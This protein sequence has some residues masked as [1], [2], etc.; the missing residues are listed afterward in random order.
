MLRSDDTQE[1]A[2]HVARPEPRAPIAGFTE[3]PRELPLSDRVAE[4]MREAIVDGTFKPG[5]L[6]P[7]ERELGDD[8]GVSRT[9]VREAIRSLAAKGMLATR[10]G[11]G[12]RVA[13][14]DSQ[15]VADSLH[16][17]LQGIGG[18]DYSSVHEVRTVLERRMAHLAAE[19]AT[20]LQVDELRQVLEHMR[21]ATDAE[22][23]SIEDVNFHRKIAEMTENPLFPVLMDSIR[24]V[25]LEIRRATLSVPGRSAT[26]VGYH[27]R[28]LD[29]I[30][31]HDPDGA[32]REMR[33]HL[34]ESYRIWEA[35]GLAHPKRAGT[36]SRGR[37]H[38][39]DAPVVG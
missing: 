13:A 5:D 39:V 24:G 26:A 3:M 34:Q 27:E 10:S 14:V 23:A 36:R 37:P 1:A 7:S 22:A 20:D 29:R 6:L 18:V 15:V 17:Y 9:V 28:I 25:L 2:N 4:R 35:A 38:P 32:E 21:A 31:Q 30:E 19:R 8:F 33:D 12:V 11:R 16:L